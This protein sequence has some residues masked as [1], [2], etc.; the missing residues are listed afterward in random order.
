MNVK[1]EYGYIRIVAQFD[2]CIVDGWEEYWMAVE[3]LQPVGGVGDRL[4]A[5]ST[6]YPCDTLVSEFCT[7]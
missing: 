6:A 2:F 5:E 4:Y 3:T 1:A 7:Q